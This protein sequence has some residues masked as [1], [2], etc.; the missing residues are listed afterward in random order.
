MD[1]MQ[2]K[3]SKTEHTLSLDRNKGLT[4]TGIA[5]ILRFDENE[6]VL[7]LDDSHLVIAGEA[8]RIGKLL[9]EEGKLDIRG[10]IDS[11]TYEAPNVVRRIFRKRGL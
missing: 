1:Q 4:A 7:K 6:V 8:M 10:R 3:H 11:I 2:I 5:D 9:L